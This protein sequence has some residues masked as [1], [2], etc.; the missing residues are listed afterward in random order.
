[1]PV[2][3][4]V[5]FGFVGNRMLKA[6]SLQTEQ[7][8]LEGAT[9]QQVDAAITEFGFPMGP[10]AMGDLAG[11]DIGWRIRKAIG[12]DAEGGRAEIADALCEMGRFG[13]KTG[14]GYYIYEKGA[15]A[16]IPDPEVEALIVET[17]AKNGI[18]RREISSEEI[19]ERLIYPMISEGAKIL[20][21][22]IAQRSGDVDVVWIYGY[23]FPVWRGGPMFY[24]DQVGLKHIC[25]RLDY[26]AGQTGN[27]TLRPA[28]LLE[29][30]ADEGV[31]FASLAKKK[32]RAA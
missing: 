9:P 14:R 23:G 24:A 28:P 5:C 16:G 8:L 20:D 30:L 21:E 11:L 27:D 31:G 26:Y 29:R 15:R 1:V 18:K 32:D 25:D 3:V 13:Q 12:A 10:F 17:A 2:V 19:V 6:R 4:G 22:G 7:L